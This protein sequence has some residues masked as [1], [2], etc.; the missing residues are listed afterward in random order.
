M[1]PAPRRENAMPRILRSLG[2][3]PLLLLAVQG[4]ATDQTYAAGIRAWQQEHDTDVRTGGWLLLIGRY[5]VAAGASSIGSDPGSTIVLPEGAPRHLGVL[6]RSGSVFRFAPASGLAA[7]I[8][9]APAAASVEL[10][11]ERG[12][13]R[14]AAQL[15]LRD[16]PNRR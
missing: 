15:L 10:I 12:K 2:L 16:S 7:T 5:E 4:S 14:V 9:G 3:L 6:T 13:G 8:D 1:L 11:T